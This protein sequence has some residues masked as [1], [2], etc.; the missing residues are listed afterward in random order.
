MRNFR[1]KINPPSPSPI[2]IKEER[3]IHF[4]PMCAV[5]KNKLQ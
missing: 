2:H 1:G 5:L 4:Y 3:L